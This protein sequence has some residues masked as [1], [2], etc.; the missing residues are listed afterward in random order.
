M[1]YKH[2]IG[3][4]QINNKGFRSTTSTFDT[5]SILSTWASKR[6]WKRQFVSVGT[7]VVQNFSSFVGV[8]QG[9][10]HCLHF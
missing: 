2:F 7:D 5:L 3:L 6:F 9:S 10:S 8:N 4:Q 1:L